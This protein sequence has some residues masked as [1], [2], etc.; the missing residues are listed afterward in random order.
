[1]THI[2]WRAFGVLSVLC[3]A[4]GCG[5]DGETVPASGGSGGAGGSAGTSS[6]GSAGASGGAAG[7]G[8][9]SGGTTS[10]GGSAGASGGAAGGGG[11]SCTT[12]L[13]AAT[14]VDATSAK[15]LSVINDPA[16]PGGIFDP[17]V[18]YPGTASA[19]AMSYSAVVAKNAIST[20]IAVS[21][22][23]GA[24]WTYVASPNA[25]ADITVPVPPSS[26]R[27][28]GGTCTGRL[29][30]EVASLVYDADDPDATR[31]WKLFTHSYVVLQNGDLA[32]D[33]G[34]I[35]LY[36]AK[37]TFGP[38]KFEGKA[39]GWLSESEFSS[40]DAATVV[41]T[42]VTTYANLKDC[43]AL[44]E[45]AAYWR[46]GGIL[47][48]AVGCVTVNPVTIRIELLRSLDHGKTFDYSGR[49]LSAQDAYCLGASKPQ[50][51]AP[52]IF[53]AQG[54]TWMLVT[55]AGSLPGGG[56]GYR[57]CALLELAVG[58][59]A[60][61]RDAGGSPIVTRF[62]DSADKRFTGACSYAEGATAMGYLVPQANIQG[63]NVT[64]HI[65]ES[66]VNAP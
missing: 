25:S 33:L 52:D 21:S 31:V 59:T 19:G 1:V 55:P 41:T 54:K 30:H 15:E 37:D 62:L 39:L 8:G 49:L 32:Y 10:S 45:P 12:T 36:T 38:W 56:E 63:T 17:S 13:P 51:N 50:V 9:A 60:V 27:C 47:D 11:A 7:S 57:G 34:Y 65:F 14:V 16:A 43:V 53:T 2:G 66:A 20:R 35:G 6:G 23:K 40:K 58:G 64:F 5:S 26:Q 22:D 18:E 29:V 28:P 46:N 44:T 24:T 48:L 3:W 42:A 61:K 4:F